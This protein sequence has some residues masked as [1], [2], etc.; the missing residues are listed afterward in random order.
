MDTTQPGEAVATPSLEEKIDAAVA[1]A[2][3]LVAPF[4]AAAAKAIEMGA[5][6]EPAFSAAIHAFIAL[7]KHS[8]K[9]QSATS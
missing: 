9:K 2:G 3:Q 6:L 1:E 5:E 7:F 8:V 4:N